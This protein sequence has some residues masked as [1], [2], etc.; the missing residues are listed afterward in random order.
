M[1]RDPAIVV[2]ERPTVYRPSDD[3]YLLLGAVSVAPGERVL[4]VGAGAGL[5]ALHAAQ[6]ANT[7][8]TDMNPDAVEL[9]CENAWRNHVP[10][11]VVRTDLMAGLRGP[12]DAVAFNPPYL[13][14]RPGDILE[15]AWGGGN[16][17]S[18]VALRFLEDLPRVLAPD[19]RAYLILSR[20]NAPARTAAE[21]SFRVEVVKS[22]PLFFERL[23]ALELRKGLE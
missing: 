22:V 17:G 20:D 7:V 13:A 5:V 1:R 21:T 11:R 15:R 12:F 14:E 16:A 6:V 3:S 18:E 8:A 9:I 10:L 19:G 23:D 2:E 4:E